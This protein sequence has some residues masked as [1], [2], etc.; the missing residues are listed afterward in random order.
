[1]TAFRLFAL[2][3][4]VVVAAIGWN[5]AGL[6]GVV[7]GVPAGLFVGFYGLMGPVLIFGRTSAG[8]VPR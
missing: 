5:V 2:I 3:G 8:A 4:A 7:L 6:F 1:M